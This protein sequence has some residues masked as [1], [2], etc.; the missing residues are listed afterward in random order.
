MAE[1]YTWLVY[2]RDASFMFCKIIS[3]TGRILQ[4]TALF[5]LAG[6]K[7]HQT[8]TFCLHVNGQAFLEFTDMTLRCK[9]KGKENYFT[10][11]CIIKKK[12]LIVNNSTIPHTKCD[13]VGLC[14][15]KCHVL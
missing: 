9:S 10:W 2:D 12:I 11:F 7:G 4:N 8:A 3:L 13:F 14:N 6:L 15:Q 1:T 5:H